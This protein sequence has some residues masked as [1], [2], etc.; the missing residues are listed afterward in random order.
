LAGKDGGI[1]LTQMQRELKR[2]EHLSQVKLHEGDVHQQ[3]AGG[4]KDGNQESRMMVKALM[5]NDRSLEDMNPLNS[6]E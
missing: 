6:L 5:R 3:N 4:Q 1:S 2:G